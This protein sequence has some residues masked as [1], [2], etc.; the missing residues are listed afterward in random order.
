MLGELEYV[1]CLG[2]EA[3]ITFKLINAVDVQ[4]LLDVPVS[5]YIHTG[6]AIVLEVVAEFDIVKVG[7]KN[8]REVVYFLL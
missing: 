7:T 8:T 4:P 6:V 5:V 2:V 1:N 3:E